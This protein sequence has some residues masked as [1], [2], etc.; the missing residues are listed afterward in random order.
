MKKPF[1]VVT[2]EGHT[3]LGE[4]PKSFLSYHS[5]LKIIGEAQD[6]R[7]YPFD[8][9]SRRSRACPERGSQH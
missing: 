7:V 9:V 8:P 6:G 3:I 2:A 5:D 4:G 1:K